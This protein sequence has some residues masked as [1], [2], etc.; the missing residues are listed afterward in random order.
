MTKTPTAPDQQTILEASASAQQKHSTILMKARAKH[1]SSGPYV[2]INRVHFQI[3]PESAEKC[4]RRARLSFVC[5]AILTAGYRR[6]IGNPEIQT[7]C[8]FRMEYVLD[9]V[10]Y[11]VNNLDIRMV[12]SIFFPSFVS[13]CASLLFFFLCALAGFFATHLILYS[14]SKLARV[15]N[16][17][18]C[19]FYKLNNLCYLPF[20]SQQS[21]SVAIFCFVRLSDGFQGVARV[22]M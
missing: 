1:K 14:L 6:A 7:V 4:G 17:I 20:Q 10:L 9:M 3:T 22:R 11:I 16:C 5:T 15:T 8:M 12:S 2:G 19:D 21:F 18:L 13:I